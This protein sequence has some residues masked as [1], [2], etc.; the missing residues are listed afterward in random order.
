VIKINSFITSYYAF[1]TLTQGVS[2]SLGLATLRHG[3]NLASWLGIHTIGALPWMGGS[4]IGGDFGSQ[5][6]DQN[7]G[8]FYFAQDP[9]LVKDYT[10]TTPLPDCLMREINARILSKIYACR[11][12]VNL[13]ERITGIEL[14]AIIDSLTNKQQSVSESCTR[15][16]NCQLMGLN[17]ARFVIAS[18]NVLCLPAIK[19]HFSPEQATGFEKDMTHDDDDTACSTTDYFSPLNCGILGCIYNGISWKTPHR[20]L[21]DPTRVIKGLALVSVSLMAIKYA[22]TYYAS[23]LIAHR[24]AVLAGAILAII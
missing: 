2:D 12:S 18:L 6:T 20:I 22:T 16:E 13:V 5:H 8:R 24:T 23:L 21:N 1:R 10:N 7:K 19:F 17:F 11:S 9:G 4:R 14:S 3:T 15:K